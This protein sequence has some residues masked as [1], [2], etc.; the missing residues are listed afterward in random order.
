[1][2]LRAALV[3]SVALIAAT[4]AAPAFAQIEPAAP[5]VTTDDDLPLGQ[6]RIRSFA[7]ADG[8]RNLIVL[9]IVQDG[10]GM[11]WVATDDG[12]YRY[13][14]QQFTHYS[15]QDGLPAMGVRVLGVAPDGALCAG[16][17][18]GMACWNGARFSPHGAEGVPHT[19]VQALA[20][21]PGVLWA[22]T[23]EGLL[24]RRGRG[25][26][27]P[28]PGWPLRP[29]RS[30]KAIWADAEGVVVG[31]DAALMLGAGDGAWRRLG[32]EVGLGGERIESV[33]RDRDGTLWI[34]SVH[35]L[36][37]L[38]R[39]AAHVVDLSDG[40]PDGS[41]MSGVSCGMAIAPWGDVLIGT[42]RGVVRRRAG[43]WQMLDAA[44]G[45]P[46]REARVL[47]VDREGT[48][49]IGSM[50]LYQWMG[51]GLIARDNMATGLPDDTVWTIGR[52]RHNT[53]WLGTGK[54][55]ARAVDGRWSCLPASVGWTVRTF[56]FS[57]HGG[58]FLGGGPPDLLYVDPTGQATTL[59]LQGERVADRHIMAAALGPDGDLWL[60]TTSGL[61][62]LP[63]ARPGPP[64]R[65]VIPGVRPDARFISLLVADDRLWTASESGL[66][67]LD[68]GA[69]R[70]LDHSS[71][72]RAS[73]MRHV[74]RRHDG[75]MCVSFTDVDGLTCFRWD[76]ARASELVDISLADGL[77][78][79]RIYYLGEDRQ[80]RLWIGTGDGVDVV[81]ASGVDHFDEVDGL[82]G[83]DATARAFFEDGDGSLWL[84]SST[85]VSHVL[86]QHY[87]GPPIA[88]RTT[89]LHSALGGAPVTAG[90]VGPIRVPHERNSV[91][92]S[93]AADSFLD[94]R[95]VEFQVRLSPLETEW[96]T[97]HLR[98]ARYPALP[99]GSYQLEIR[100]RTGAGSWGPPAELRFAVLPAWWQ[101]RWFIGLAGGLVLVSLGGAVTWRQRVLWRRRALQ[102]SQQSDARFRELIEAMPD[103]VS[104]HRDDQLVYLNQ[105]ARQMLGAGATRE[106]RQVNL[107]DR[108]H[109]DDRPRAA[110]LFAETQT[111]EAPAGS[112][113]V[114]LRLAAGDGA[115]RHCEL[116]GR[117]IDLGDGPV[118]VLTG[119]DV[120]ERDRLRS[121]LML[122][123]RM[124]SLG[125]L[126]AGIAHEI[127][128]PLAYV[129]ANL[130]VVA[131][132]L[133]AAPAASSP[134][135][136]AEHAELQAA[137][138]D[139]REGAER[140][141]KIVRGLRSFSRSE[142]EKRVPIALSDVLGAA[143]RL[144]RNEVKHRAVLV[145][146]LG[147][148]PAVLADD[149]RLTQ[150][151]INLLV[152]A[153]HAIPEGHTD[154]NR[155]TVR[156]GTTPD[157]RASA[158]I[159]D[160]GASM[161][162]EVLARAFD[163]FFTTKEVGEGTGLGLSICHGIISGLGGQITIDSAPGR[164][165]LVRVVLPPARA[166][167]AP[168]PPPA[169]AVTEIASRRRR[170][171]I[172]D[173]EPRVAQALERMLQTDYDL[174]LVACGATALEHI[175]A[176]NRYD[177]IITDVMMP[178]MTG[179][180]LFDRLQLLSAEQASR[181]IFLTGGVFTPQTQAR[182]E[183]AGNPQLQKPIGAQ[184]LRTCVA[185]LLTSPRRPARISAPPATTPVHDRA[186]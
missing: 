4:R 157:G 168:A 10:D 58:V 177:A 40:L 124:V 167:A 184:E 78:S 2:S 47:F 125:T 18:D 27:E 54:C 11:L 127:N 122:S 34:R 98:E 148:T 142:E 9:G 42:E 110:R 31:D 53:L 108:I 132:S 96:S 154:A 175:T 56:V 33:L 150:V 179:I 160:T 113:A 101:T 133:A 93:F 38:A 82:A 153:A 1:M 19:S 106:P 25:A 165:C 186:G 182:L 151:F 8:L 46:V 174:T 85:G 158:E 140:V 147:D 114:E 149:G 173:D 21:G 60:A 138:G 29:A 61:Y 22:G 30:V 171:L 105:A 70:L 72:F 94:P 36:W 112:H 41:D 185:T 118:V 59:E 146:D 5:A 20:A 55:L 104:V 16:T 137:I 129:S 81:T 43:R 102:L 103:L 163:P 169:A 79:G 119:R 121:K 88:P 176:G 66:A 141:R 86:A 35:H 156:T 51:R 23:T 170:V 63:G 73:A 77:T 74:I 152:N 75:R 32:A 136:Q 68:H 90:A 100:A 99:P 62:R 91:T 45:I 13:D 128:N 130:E 12:V 15:M 84:G 144:T 162:P 107:I 97:T 69:W 123:D 3:T 87:R 52:D 180:E 44:V 24:I 80:Q 14:G 89:V 57:P 17:R 65:V 161:P 134:A 95:R 159:E 139:A 178:N 83:N 145:L 111:A 131:E 50:G 143:I 26:F 28:A 164:G 67:V 116:S 126:A 7:A 109:P 155:I 166:E 172:V 181:V 92:A 48:V 71:G 64:E 37:T 6:F 183:A 115:W 117:R 76:G 49:W 120:T 135:Q 39:G